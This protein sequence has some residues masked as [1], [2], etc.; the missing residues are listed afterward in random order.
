MSGLNSRKRAGAWLRGLR[1]MIRAGL[2]SHGRKGQHNHSAD[3]TAISTGE[4][5][6][7]G[8]K[9]SRGGSPS[10]SPR[11]ALLDSY[12]GNNLGDASIQDAMIANIGLRLP[13]AQFY[14]IT[15]NSENFV[16]QHGVG[17]FPLV[18]RYIPSYGMS[19]ERYAEQPKERESP[20]RAVAWGRAIKSALKRVPIL[21]LCLPALA[22]IPRE[23]FHVVGGYRFLRGKDLLVVSGGGQLSEEWGGAWGHPFALFKWAVLA[24]F[25]RVPYVFAS[26]GSGVVTSRAGR[27]FVSA[28]LRM[29][30]YRSYR[31]KN[32]REIATGLMGRVAADP[33]V[34][35][36]AFSLPSSE[37]PPPSGIREIAQGRTVVAIS[38]ISYAKPG[39][40]SFENGALYDRY[41]QQMAQVLSRLLGRGCF[42]VIV[43]SSLGHDETVIPDLLGR[44][45]DESKQRLAGQM[46]IPKITTWKHLVA[47]LRDVDW[48]IASRL[49]STILGFMSET[50]TI[51]ISFDPKVDWVMEDL[52][53]TDYLLQIRDV[54]CDDVIEALDRLEL[55]KHVVLQQIAS[56]R[57]RAASVFA[58]QYDTLAQLTVGQ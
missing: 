32:T 1:E 10:S 47:T 38:L 45:D 39:F 3:E 53:Q 42:L 2:I 12:L 11:I 55:R 31:D 50:P 26:V 15:L 43:C 4:F 48:L 21:R 34:P 44:L 46:H 49:H 40:W 33:V 17:A 7:L 52:G 5:S 56:Y 13:N 8:H 23:I 58:L 27:L 25:A 28:A 16:D 14:G 6:S 51:A 30:R 22:T 18:A 20:R 41:V 37:L 36:L 19:H 9:I 24:R 57:Q 29:A 35:D 54:T